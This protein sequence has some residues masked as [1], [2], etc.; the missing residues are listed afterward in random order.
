[1][2]KRS[3]ARAGRLFARMAV[4]EIGYSGAEAARYPGVALFAVNRLASS[5]ELDEMNS[6]S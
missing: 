5:N 4:N 3:I 2:S 6:Y 1:M